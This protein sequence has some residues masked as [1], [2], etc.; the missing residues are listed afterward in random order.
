MPPIRLSLAQ[1]FQSIRQF[2][3]S[4]PLCKHVYK[5]GAPVQKF[6]HPSHPDCP[7]YP[8]GPAL[9]YKQSNTGLYGGLRIQFGN[10][11]SKGRNK[12]KTRRSWHPNVRVQSLWSDAL[13]K[14]VKCKVTA[15]VLRT[16]DKDGGLDNYLLGDSQSRIQELGIWGWR[17]R[18]DVIN[19]QKVQERF[20]QQRQKLGFLS[21]SPR[22]RMTNV[23][24]ESTQANIGGYGETEDRT[25]EFLEAADNEVE[26]TETVMKDALPALDQQKPGPEQRV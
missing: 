13:E 5:T 24:K 11:I 3:I 18:W 4:I 6:Y 22:E 26:G 8:Y 9:T 16:I 7:P 15:R 14:K 12:G 17:L 19:T 23:K 1:P 25:G 21:E 10:K 2:S 20:R